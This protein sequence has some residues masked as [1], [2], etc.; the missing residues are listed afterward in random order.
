VALLALLAR[1]ADLA[2]RSC[3]ILV[4]T[5]SPILLALPGATILEIGEDGTTTRIDYDDAQ[6]VRLTREF[7]AAPERLLRVLL[8]DDG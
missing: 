4:A 1:L 8:D 6:P 3:R 5:H 2:A 7:L